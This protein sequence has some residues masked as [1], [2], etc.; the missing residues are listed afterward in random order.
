MRIPVP[1][2]GYSSGDHEPT[3][4]S[5]VPPAI[6]GRWVYLRPYH[7]SDF[8]YF[9]SWRMDVREHGIWNSKVAGTKEEYAE[10]IARMC[11]RS[12]VLSV[13]DRTSAEPIGLAQ[14]YDFSLEHGWTSCLGY[15][16]P[17]YRVR[18][19]G[20]EAAMLFAEY[21]F[22]SYPIRKLY[23]D[24]LE[25]NETVLRTLQSVGFVVEGRRTEH[26]LFQGKYWDLYH[27]AL[28]RSRWNEVRERRLMRLGLLP[29]APGPQRVGRE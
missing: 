10:E 29:A 27:L 18:A 2:R 15:I 19:H 22:N 13:I 1:R 11:A 16:E 6:G 26:G 23:A 17:G 9:Y 5:P 8:P 21:L 25:F 4:S 12:I 20:A 7:D 24:V 14:A 28:T 3:E